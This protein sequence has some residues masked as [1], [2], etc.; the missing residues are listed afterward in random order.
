MRA[1]TI[2]PQGPFLPSFSICT[3]KY[4]VLPL[5]PKSNSITSFFRWW[6]NVQKHIAM[7][8]LLRKNASAI[9]TVLL[10]AMDGGV[11]VIE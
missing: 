1:E 9:A 8:F 6:R 2:G 7:A 5:S 11:C 3:A 4:A 10:A